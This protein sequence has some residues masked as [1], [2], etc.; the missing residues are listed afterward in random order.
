M[1]IFSVF[2]ILVSATF[3]AIVGALALLFLLPLSS[4]KCSLTANNAADINPSISSIFINTHP[5]YVG[6]YNYFKLNAIIFSITLNKSSNIFKSLYNSSFLLN[7]P[8]KL[9]E[10]FIISGDN[11]NLLFYYDNALINA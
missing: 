9:I 10:C 3:L 11:N 6:L 5:F 7:L 1:Y 2:I 4:L 8:I